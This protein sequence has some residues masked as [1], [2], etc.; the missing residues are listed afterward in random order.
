MPDKQELE[1]ML[2]NIIDDKSEQAQTH[3]HS[4]LQ[5]KM[6]EVMKGDD[7]DEAPAGE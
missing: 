5:D 2:A 1:N 7:E 3:F 6:R 4:Y